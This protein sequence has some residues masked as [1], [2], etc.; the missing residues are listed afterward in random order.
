MAKDSKQPEVNIGLVGHVDHGKTTLTEQL[1]SKWTDTHSEELKRGITIKL[2]YADTSFYKTKEGYSVKGKKEELLRK[3]SIVDAPGH[4]SLMATML[5]GATLMDGAILLIAANEQCPQPQTREHLMALENSGIKNIVV[6]QNKIDLV[7]DKKVMKNYQQI[8]DFLKGTSYEDAPI[9]PISAG[10]GIN[11]DYLIQAIE[12]HIPT[13]ERNFDKD[14]L[15][16][17]ARSFDINKPGFTPDKLIGGVLGG[18]L[19]QGQLSVDEEIEIR[20][21]RIY[22]EHNKLKAQPIKT[23]LKK[24]MSGNT[25]FDKIT[26][27]GSMGLLTELDPGIVKSDSLGGSIA[28]RPGKLPGILY[29]VKMKV[30]L[31]D[32]VVGSR[33]E[34]KVDPL[35]MGEPLMLNVN[36]AATIGQI[37]HLGNK[38]VSCKLKLPICAEEGA[39][40]SISR[41]VGSRFRLIG[42]GV[43]IN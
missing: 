20:P 33:A 4:E 17:V 41:R 22:E 35:K 9:I 2:G 37:T 18:V 27:G 39:R 42:Y 14:P 3:I 12:E 7:D 6:A 24:I 28:G 32:R 8:K 38:E 30:Y 23:T 5:A 25:T 43:L 31:L 21:G 15:F 26:P 36:S 29:E 40:I 34:L 16:L 11:I 10:R 1:S 13:P 19:L